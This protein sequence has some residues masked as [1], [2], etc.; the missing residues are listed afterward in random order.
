[1]AEYYPDEEIMGFIFEDS[2]HKSFKT[3]TGKKS[4]HSPESIKYYK[5]VLEADQYVMSILKLGLKFQFSKVPESYE[6]INNRSARDNDRL[7]WEN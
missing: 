2:M 5:E 6:E 3:I 7:L 4:I 1:M